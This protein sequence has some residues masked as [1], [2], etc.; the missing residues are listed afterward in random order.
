VGG[1]EFTSPGHYGTAAFDPMNGDRLA[2]NICD[3]CL[4]EFGKAGA[5]LQYTVGKRKPRMWRVPPH[6]RRNI[7]DK[8]LNASAIEARSGE[9][10]KSGS[11]EGESATA[12]PGRPNT[13]TDTPQ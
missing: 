10:P 1:I 12:T 7:R 2:I 8:Y 6:I 3:W 13:I 4:V 9:T 11:T 5:I